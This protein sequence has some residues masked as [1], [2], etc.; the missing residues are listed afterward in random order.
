MDNQGIYYFHQGTSRRAYELLGAHYTEKETVFRV[1]APHAKRVSIVGDFNKWNQEI[2]PCARITDQ[3][4]WECTI[5]NVAEFSCYQIA[6][7]TQNDHWI[8]K[9]DPYAFHAEVRPAKASK[10]YNLEGFKFSDSAWM[11]KRKKLQTYEQPLNIY[12]VHL[13][14]WRKYDDGNYFDYE[15][16][17]Y[18]LCDYVKK[19]KYTHIEIMPVSEYPYDPSWGYQVTG[20]YAITS[21][22]GTPK[23]FMK[24][25]DIMHKAGIGVIV[26]WVPGHFNKDANGLI[27]FDGEPLYEPSSEKRKELKGWG[28]RCFDYGRC[29]VQSFLVSNAY[30][31]LDKFHIDGLR[32]DAVESMLYLD[33]GRNE[34]EYELNSYG[35]NINLESIAFIKKVNQVIKDYDPSVL[36]IAE[37][38]TTYQKVTEPI[39]NG[40]LGFDYKWNMGWMNDSLHYLETD[41]MY[42]RYH[43]DQISFQLTYIFSEHYVLALSHDE[44]VHLKKAMINKVPGEYIQKFIGLKTYYLYMMTHPGK[45]LTFMGN[46]FGQFNEWNE[47]KELDWGCLGYDP[48]I[49]LQKFNIDLNKIYKKYPALHNDT[50]GWNGF[51]WL[52]VN[53]RDHNVFAYSRFDN[54]DTFIVILNFAYC[55]WDNYQLDVENG[56]Y[57]VIINSNDLVYNGYNKENKKKIVVTDNKLNI[58]LVSG[59][60]M[61]MRKA[62]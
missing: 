33:Y 48:H 5:P 55:D 41:P 19:M 57:E 49:G 51:K 47:L 32:V 23:D 20:F 59:C 6:I 30:F 3:G 13:G 60:G 46:E 42:R 11:R 58:K 14:S 40:G 21:R 28:T 26:D 31:L 10:V 54:N 25:V 27:D 43:H 24:F 53:D 1:Y 29:E 38:S 62:G 8:L 36:I 45:K 12:E 34:G 7:L 16:L 44:V 52:S 22:Y 37:E 50:L 15:K 35:T 39:D 56:V 17:A 4:L 2:N 61:M 18:E 9:S